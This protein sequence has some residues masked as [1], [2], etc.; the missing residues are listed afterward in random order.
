MGKIIAAVFFALGLMPAM[1]NPAFDLGPAIG[2]P[3][4]SL[5]E[6]LD[7]AGK[8]RTLDSL[9]GEKGLVLFFVRSASWC[10]YCKTQI[11]DLNS[12]L[13][14]IGKRGYR[15]AGISYDKPEVQ[16]EVTAEHQIKYPLLS[17]PQSAVID[18]FKLRDPQ[19]KPGSRAYG[20][21]RPIIFI[22]DRKGV[23]RAKLYEETYRTRPPLP[24]ILD[25][26]DKVS[27]Q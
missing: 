26:L 4:P 10:P 17:D 14:E 7:A 18:R 23:I 2:T 13:G 8:P 3:A 9:M 6:P 27:A 1:A 15:L 20:V 11:I 12:G 25:A 16:A 22:L 21:P 5:G 24:V 19:Y